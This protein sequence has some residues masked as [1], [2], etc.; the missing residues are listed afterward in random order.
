MEVEDTQTSHESPKKHD[1]NSHDIGGSPGIQ[2]FHGPFFRF[3]G[4]YS[5]SMIIMEVETWTILRLD[6]HLPG[7]DFPLP[8]LL[9]EE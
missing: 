4:V 5:L 2:N 1:G 3:S 7:P 9:E 6:T 8:W